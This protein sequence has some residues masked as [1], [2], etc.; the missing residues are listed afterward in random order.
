M[1]PILHR[2]RDNKLSLYS[3]YDFSSSDAEANISIPHENHQSIDD[4]CA[5]VAPNQRNDDESDNF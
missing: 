2:P 1:R 5:A 3:D 4:D